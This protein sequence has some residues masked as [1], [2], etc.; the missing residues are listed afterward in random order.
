MNFE[1]IVQKLCDLHHL[2]DVMS[3]TKEGH[4]TSVIELSNIGYRLSDF[5]RRLSVIGFRMSV[6]GHRMVQS[7]YIG[8]K[9]I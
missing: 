3:I 9:I 8:N 4:R 6:F 7:K 1:N 2:K 5:G